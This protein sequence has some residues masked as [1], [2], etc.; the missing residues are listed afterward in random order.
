MALLKILALGN[1]K[2]TVNQITP[3][4]EAIVQICKI[5]ITTYL[6]MIYRKKLQKK[7]QAE[8]WANTDYSVGD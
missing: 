2:I 4:S 8:A 5:Y 6:I 1:A 3:A 7:T